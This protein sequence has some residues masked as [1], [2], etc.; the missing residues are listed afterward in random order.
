MCIFVISSRINC[1]EVLLIT[2]RTKRSIF[3]FLISI[4]IIVLM[5]SYQFVL[6]CSSIS[7][8]LSGVLVIKTGFENRTELAIEARIKGIAI[9]MK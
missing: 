3:L 9:P 6:F 1:R 4:I 2:K 8:V 5:G 7:I